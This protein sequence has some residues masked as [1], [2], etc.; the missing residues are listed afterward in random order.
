[1]KWEREER[2]G[3]VSSKINLCCRHEGGKRGRQG[4]ESGFEI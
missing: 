1:L 3:V 4:L 2:F